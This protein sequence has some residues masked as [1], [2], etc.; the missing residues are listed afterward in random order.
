MKRLA[1][2]LLAL[3]VALFVALLLASCV[4]P[5]TTGGEIAVEISVDGGRRS[6]TLPVGSTVQNAVDRAGVELGQIDRVEPPAYTVLVDGAEVQVIRREERFEI[7]ELVIPFGRQTV[8]NEGLPEGQTRLL[9][10]G[11]NG[12]EEITFRIVEEEGTEI[13]RQAVK[14]SLV[15]E[16]RPEIIMVGAQE[17]HTPLAIEGTIAF[18]SGGNAWVMTGNTAN[19]RPVVASGD[20]DGQVFRISADGNWLLFTRRADED[21]D[22]FNELWVVDLRQADPEPLDLGIE[23]VVHFADWSPDPES[24]TLAY[25]T[26]EPRQSAPGWQANNDLAL[27]TLSSSG[28]VLRVRELLAP[29]PGGQYGW[30]GTDFVWA[31]DGVHLAY[32][33]PDAVG[34]LDTRQPEFQPLHQLTPLLTGGDWA[35]VPG[36]AWGSNSQVLYTVNHGEPVG[37]E[38]P[39]ASPVFDLVALDT[40]DRPP[41]TL[42]RRIGM[43]AYPSVSPSQPLESGE[44]LS[45]IALLQAMAP[46]ESETSGYRLMVM[47]RDGSNLRTLFPATGEPGIQQDELAPPVWSPDG[48]LLAVV[49]RGDLWIVDAQSGAGEQLTG[50]GLTR[51]VDWKP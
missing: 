35:W 45:R 12:V 25:S 18:L 20:L 6:V 27:L 37:I 43:F 49:Y 22:D 23:N 3:L 48:R 16:P 47:D 4:S 7:E 17:A 26:A 44:S 19:R 28:R 24:R 40:E 14:R 41:L 29:N 39:G 33:Q 38:D 8:R 1:P 15:Q 5:R 9:Q 46:L 34:I 13:S 36:L 51:A 50:D 21:S 30:W 2:W 11:Q 42:V 31:P 10:A 32:A